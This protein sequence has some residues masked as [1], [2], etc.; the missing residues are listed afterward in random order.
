MVLID[1]LF[2]ADT[3]ARRFVMRAAACATLISLTA[4]GHAQSRFEE[5]FDD[6]KKPWQEIAVQLPAAPA[7]ENLIPF[8]VSA[9]ATQSFA[10][11]GN[12]VTV[13]GDGVVRYTMVT[14]SSAGASNI[15]YEGIRCESFEKKLYAFGR[16]DGSWSRSRRDQWEPIMRNAANRQHAALATEYFCQ[17][18][19]IAGN[20]QNIVDRLRQQ[21]SLAPHHSR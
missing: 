5:E 14:Q 10:V 19:T 9:T 12:S 20:A 21:K 3:S 7:A 16:S 17:E 18:K 11:D 13:G 4:L 1:F 2:T 6:E 8:Y 15:S